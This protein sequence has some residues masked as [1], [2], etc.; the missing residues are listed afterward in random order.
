MFPSHLG[1]LHDDG[2]GVVVV[3]VLHG[4]LESERCHHEQSVQMGWFYLSWKSESQTDH[5]QHG[6]T[7]AVFDWSGIIECPCGASI[8]IRPSTN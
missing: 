1:K 7:V 2:G 5:S 4:R 6:L 8:Q 3:V